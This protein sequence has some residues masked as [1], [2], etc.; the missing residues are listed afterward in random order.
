MDSVADRPVG[1]FGEVMACWHLTAC[2]GMLCG[3]CSAPSPKQQVPALP[4]AGEVIKWDEQLKPGS[5]TG[6]K[7]NVQLFFFFPL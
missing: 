2:L 1:E 6:S 5:S 7:H 3:D 4:H